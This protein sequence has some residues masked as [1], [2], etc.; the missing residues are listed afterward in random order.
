[1]K[2]LVVLIFIY[3]PLTLYS[4]TQSELNLAEKHKFESIEEEM[5]A[6]YESIF[7]EYKGYDLFLE[8]LK[9]SQD[10]WKDYRELHL[11]ALYPEEDKLVNYGSVYP[12]CYWIEMSQLTRIRKDEL[13][14]WLK[15]KP[16]GE[17]CGGSI[18]F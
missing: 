6:I 18:K 13:E 4:Q 15:A 9:R 16:Q 12:M 8:K 17:V 2:S 7:S 10:A 3:L 5:E 1:M 11:E 14:K